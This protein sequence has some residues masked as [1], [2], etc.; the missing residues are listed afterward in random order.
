MAHMQWHAVFQVITSENATIG[1]LTERKR[2]PICGWGH[3]RKCYNWI[4]GRTHIPP[5]FPKGSKKNGVCLKFVLDF[6]VY[7]H[8]QM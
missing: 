7:L 6:H 4:A 5:S 3:L 2:T 8:S 1:S